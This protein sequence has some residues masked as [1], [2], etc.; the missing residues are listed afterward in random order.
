MRTVILAIST[1]V[2]AIL[3]SQGLLSLYKAKTSTPI[4]SEFPEIVTQSFVQWKGT[5]Q[6]AYSSGQEENYRLTVFLQNYQK[7]EESNSNPAHTFK[8]GLTAFADLTEEE[9]SA[10]Y[11]TANLQVNSPKENVDEAIV[12][13]PVTPVKEKDWRKDHVVTPVRNQGICK[14]YW[15][16]S[17]MAALESLRAIQGGPL[18][19]LSVQQLIDCDPYSNGCSGGNT[20]TALGYT[21]NHGVEKDADYKYWGEA[22]RFWKKCTYEKSKTVFTPKSYKR[23]GSTQNALKNAL[24]INPIV[25]NIYS[26]AFAFQHYRQGVFNDWDGCTSDYVNH[27]ALAVGFG[28]ESNGQKFWVIKNS[29]GTRWG[30]TGYMRMLRYE[31]DNIDEGICLITFKPMYPTM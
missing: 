11:L 15:S 13:A 27:A 26:K 30:E 6:K 1:I 12:G 9:F 20:D 21:M 19:H 23:V 31:N 18:E 29:W 8:L 10:K 22:G 25:V 2:G 16:F 5:H 24:L 14:S 3:L 28:E 4:P 17:T 7:I